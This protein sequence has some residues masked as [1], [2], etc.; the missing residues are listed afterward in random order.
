MSGSGFGAAWEHR[1]VLDVAGRCAVPRRSMAMRRRPGR[2]LYVR[3][4]AAEEGTSQ[5][6]APPEPRSTSMSV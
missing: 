5:Q 4:F 2:S 1:N 3:T 6:I